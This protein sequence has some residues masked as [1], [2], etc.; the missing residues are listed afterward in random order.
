MKGCWVLS[1]EHHTYAVA[2]LRTRYGWRPSFDDDGTAGYNGSA[3]IQDET[4]NIV[5]VVGGHSGVSASMLRLLLGPRVGLRPS[6]LT[7]G[8][9]SYA[10]DTSNHS[11][12]KNRLAR[13]KQVDFECVLNKLGQSGALQ[14]LR[15]FDASGAGA[16]VSFD[17]AARFMRYLKHN[18][19]V[20]EDIMSAQPI[21]ISNM[22]CSVK[23]GHKKADSR[24]FHRVAYVA[25]GMAIKSGVLRLPPALVGDWINAEHAGF[26]PHEHH[27]WE[28]AQLMSKNKRI[29]SI[30]S[31]VDPW[32]P[33]PELPQHSKSNCIQVHTN[34]PLYFHHALWGSTANWHCKHYRANGAAL[35]R[36]A[37]SNVLWNEGAKSWR[38]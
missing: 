14:K 30:L 23:E 11:N 12:N 33:S 34:G 35:A 2:S 29:D 9:G 4:N 16:V 10:V 20:V 15:S 38:Q 7:M 13:Q 26:E 21:Q 18:T 24:Y 5:V 19:P 25:A 22:N 27:R 36:C 17:W 31:F 37:C 6:A 32:Q 8:H 3:T 1:Q 28:R